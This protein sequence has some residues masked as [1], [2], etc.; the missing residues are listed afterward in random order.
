M[1][2]PVSD[3]TSAPIA[4]SAT[5]LHGGDLAAARRTFPDAPQPF[6]DL[7]TGINPIAYPMPQLPSELFTRLPDQAALGELA[8]AAA[9]AYGVPSGALVAAA[10]GTQILL[11]HVYALAPP[12]RA[13]VLAPTYAEH[14]RV[15]ALLGYDV[16]E[17]TDVAALKECNL[18][19]VVNPNN[20]D[21]RTLKREELLE[22]AQV[23]RRWDGLLVVDEAFMDV[24]PAHASL[25]PDV[26]QGN[27]IVL[28][29]FGKFFGLAGLRLG[30]ALAA[31]EM[32]ERLRASLG[33][34]A[35]SGAAIAV[36]TKAL[37]DEDWI[38]TTRVQLA[39]AALRLDALLREAR[40]T[41]VG[42]TSLFQTV[43]SG[44]A[45]E[46]YH[47]LGRAGVLV[48]HFPDRPH[49]LRFGLPGA[50]ADWERLRTALQYDKQGG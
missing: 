13:M 35:V 37:A 6:L 43:R 24:G 41:I 39:T 25:A 12:G 10:P 1:S 3:P 18:A 20:P 14:A 31:P 44:E 46:L 45:D 49:L 29:S 36:G 26:A 27:I 32:A 30:F 8:T 21:G 22:L 34:W 19:I 11:T 5:P 42:G 47:R 4:F 28:R 48:R 17:V 38:D 15:V 2:S 16:K 7:S 33:P 40:L 23:L 50:D 9:R